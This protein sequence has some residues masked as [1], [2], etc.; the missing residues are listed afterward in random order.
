MS[1]NL[2]LLVVYIWQKL[3]L[4]VGFRQIFTITVLMSYIVACCAYFH[5]KVALGASLAFSYM[6]F[7]RHWDRA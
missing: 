7:K 6:H 4:L 1:L 3:E 2:F 5:A